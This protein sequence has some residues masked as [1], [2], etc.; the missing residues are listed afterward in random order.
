MRK[1]DQLLDQ[2]PVITAFT[3]AVSF[4]L[5]V[6]HLG[7]AR[8]TL[9]E[10][11]YVMLLALVSLA[12]IL[13]VDALRKAPFRAEVRR[14]LSRPPAATGAPLP[15][16]ASREQRALARL[17]EQQQSAAALRLAE[18]K[19]RAEDH[20]T[21]V[22]LWVHQ[23]KTPVSVIQLAAARRDDAAWDDA[24]EE[25]E[26]LAHGLDLMLAAARLERFE[27]D[28]TPAEVDLVALA[29]SV[30]NELRGA[31]IRSGVFPRVEAPESVRGVTDP[32]WLSVA[33]RQLL[34][35]A[36][37]YSPAGSQV[38][39]RVEAAPDGA[40]LTV[41]DRGAG[42]PPEDLPK[43]FDRFFTGA[44]GRT[45]GA[46]TGMGLHVASEVCRRMGHELALESSVGAGTTATIRLRGTGLHRLE[47][48]APAPARVTGT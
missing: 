15:R 8:L 45:H 6:V 41:A 44:N 14:R 7:V 23:M 18:H 10:A 38:T 30:L 17:L 13:G 32:K 22:D 9:D 20:R 11:G 3:L 48:V 43:V 33:L 37:R 21:F 34:T 31:F 39:V 40:T 25:V 12:L 29:R 24:L 35:N 46:S 28:F 1:V 27:H 16:P 42:I 26:R 5:L 47:D 19:R 2:L 4:L 36:V